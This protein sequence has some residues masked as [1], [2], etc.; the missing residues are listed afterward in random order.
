M[1]ID[2]R[3]LLP[4]SGL[5]ALR[6]SSLM[7]IDKRIHCA[8]DTTSIPR[9]SSLMDIDKRILRLKIIRHRLVLVH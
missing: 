6:F 8:V 7:D 9:F 4:P 5:P 2:K 1:D 3:I